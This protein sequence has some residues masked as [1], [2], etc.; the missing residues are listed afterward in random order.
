MIDL[1]LA[2]SLSFVFVEGEKEVAK[3]FDD[4]AIFIF[5]DK[6]QLHPYK[7]YNVFVEAIV[8]KDLT[9]RRIDLLC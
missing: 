8:D 6:V 3:L 1:S 5:R 7:V 4:G 2:S 9:C